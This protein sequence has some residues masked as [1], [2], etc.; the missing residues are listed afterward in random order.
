MHTPKQLSRFVKKRK[1][2]IGLSPDDITFRG[3]Q[4]MDSVIMRIIDFDAK[5]FDEKTI[6]RVKEVKEYKD[7]ST[8]TWFNVD[9]LHQT[10]IIEEISEV[11]DFDNDG[12]HD[13][14]VSNTDDHPFFYENKI[15]NEGI[16]E[17]LNWV[18]FRLE[19]SDSN[20]DGLGSE[21]TLWSGAHKQKRL[22]Y[23]AGF[24]SQSLQAVHFG[25]G[26]QAM[27]DSVKIEWD[28]G[29]IENFYN[30]VAKRHYKLSEGEGF[31]IL[32][33]DSDKVY[34]CTDQTSCNYNESATVDDGSC[35]YLDAPAI[36]GQQTVG[37]LKRE[38]YSCTQS[39]GSSYH[40][41][42]ENGDI[43][44]GQ[45]TNSVSVRWGLENSGRLTVTEFNSCASFPDTLDVVLDIQSMDEHHSVARIWNEA[46][47]YAIRNDFARPTVHARN[48]YHMSL[49][50]YDAWAIYSDEARTYLIGKTVHGYSHSFDG[51]TTDGEMQSATEETISY[52]AYRILH[53]R[54]SNSPGYAASKK[55]FDRLFDEL[56][57]DRSYTSL[58][59]SD[60]SP[61][62]LGNFIAQSIIDF[63]LQ[64]GAA[65]LQSYANT[66]YES[67]NPP[68]NINKAGNSTIVDP[69]RWQPLAL[70]TFIDQAG[71]L[72]ENSTPDFLSPEWGNVA[73]FSLQNSDKTIFVREEQVY[74]VYH[75]P[76]L[77]PLLDTTSQDD[78]SDQYKSGFAMVSVWGAQLSPDDNVT[79]DISPSAIGNIDVS[80]F[81]DDF[82]DYNSFYNY[83][84]GG[85][86]G[87]GRGTNP[88]T[89]SPYTPNI[90]YRG[91]YTRVL[92][93]FWADGPDSETPPGHWFVLL[94]NV[95]DHPLTERKLQGEG[96][97]LS[98]LEWDIKS[99]F[100]MGGTMH[101]AAIAAWSIKGWYDYIRPIGAVRHLAHR[102]QCSRPELD[103]YD[104]GGIPL[105]NGYIE[106][107]QPGDELQGI[108]QQH[109]G[110]IKLYTWMGHKFISDT[111]TDE[112]GV[113][114]ILAEDWMPYQRPSFVTPPFAGYVSGHSTYSRAAAEV[115]TSLTG[116]EYFPGGI[117]EFVAHK[118]EFLVFED[119]P[120]QDVTLQ[121][122][123]YRD[124]SDQCSLSRIWGGIHPPADDIPGRII[125]EQIGIDAFEYAVPYF[126]QNTSSK[127]NIEIYSKTKMLNVEC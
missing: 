32:D 17:S 60:G 61:R 65:E 122:A 98:R 34:G 123:T 75:D 1:E 21:I 42:V 124:A 96:L 82:S 107:V 4:K 101:D 25:L 84:D 70:E 103:N 64:D 3:K 12:D 104:I 40:W 89:D 5:Q 99:Y 39:T 112:A 108:D 53:H 58:D 117:G 94:N 78:H 14:L 38:T 29:L 27:I 13:V 57:Y 45:G 85:D 10:E 102:G 51:F 93:E 67:V 125:G 41:E 9:G 52:A 105:I 8:V 106:V 121:W 47:L 43:I 90:V 115:M 63:G 49:A 28:S 74:N 87:T 62:A 48:L 76:G 113:G 110:K 46:L 81:P 109:V 116:T 66:Y 77:P 92:A 86:I 33:I 118:D 127:D 11:F 95:S 15:I 111:E 37:Y 22:Y 19:G 56:G 26:P 68:L 71:N 31:A 59:Y 55:V 23:G 7:T 18:S 100:I 16:P 35:S 73:P 72:I 44:E 30:L 24:L 126:S 120:S 36:I 6:T 83:I 97:T 79:I 91:D 88:L 50:M 80:Q 54:F 69:N 2:E 119:G 20:R 114:W